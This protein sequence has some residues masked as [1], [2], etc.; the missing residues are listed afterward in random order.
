MQNNDILN[1]YITIDGYDQQSLARTNKL[2]SHFFT[3]CTILRMP[4]G[5]LEELVALYDESFFWRL[6]MPKPTFPCLTLLKGEQ[7]FQWHQQCREV[8]RTVAV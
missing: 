4:F 2:I 8:R 5:Q 1:N 6:I 7:G 3:P